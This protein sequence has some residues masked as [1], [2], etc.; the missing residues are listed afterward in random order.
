MAL[1]LYD[2]I[3]IPGYQVWE[4]ENYRYRDLLAMVEN[5]FQDGVVTDEEMKMLSSTENDVLLEYMLVEDMLKK[6]EKLPYGSPQRDAAE[7]LRAQ[8]HRCY[9]LMDR[10]EAIG[11]NA[12]E[13]MHDQ[14]TAELN[15]S[16]GEPIMKG[17]LNI[18]TTLAGTLLLQ[19]LSS[20]ERRIEAQASVMKSKVLDRIPDHVRSELD[21]KIEHVVQKMSVHENDQAFEKAFENMA[22]M[23]FRA[24]G[25]ERE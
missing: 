16:M 9:I 7:R 8:L 15:R 13:D 21:Q 14:K 11:R 24:Q 4:V 19:E 12:N 23:R 25:R 5:V 20:P 6:A 1:E 2:E 18:S 22:V 3:K 10:A 17:A